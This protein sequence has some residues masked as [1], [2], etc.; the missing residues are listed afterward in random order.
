MTTLCNTQQPPENLASMC[1]K[2]SIM[3]GRVHMLLR[4][5]QFVHWWKRTVYY[6]HV[7]SCLHSCYHSH[8]ISSKAAT[9]KTHITPTHVNTGTTTLTVA[10]S[11]FKTIV[12][13]MTPTFVRSTEC[14]KECNRNHKPLNQNNVCKKVNCD[15]RIVLPRTIPER[16]PQAQAWWA[17]WVHEPLAVGAGIWGCHAWSPATPCVP[18]AVT[19]WASLACSLPAPLPVCLHAA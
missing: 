2:Q 9:I 5:L 13:T 7:H 16:M 3:Y 19:S 6:L 4:K 12:A 8:N 14:L 11:I 10:F 15:N 18:A 1:Y 17:V